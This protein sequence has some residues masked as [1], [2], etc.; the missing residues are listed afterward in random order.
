M[1]SH[2][3]EPIR[4]SYIFFAEAFRVANVSFDVMV[5]I[6]GVFNGIFAEIPATSQKVEKGV[7]SLFQI[8]VLG[9]A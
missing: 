5:G 3:A 8:L 7:H 6:G 1:R 4:F 9:P 2:S